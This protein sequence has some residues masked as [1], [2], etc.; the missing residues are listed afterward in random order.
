MLITELATLRF[1]SDRV[2]V[3]GILAQNPRV[4]A[5]AVAETERALPTF[6]PSTTN[7]PIPRLLLQHDPNARPAAMSMARTHTAWQK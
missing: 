5:A 3:G 7:F 2:G 1:I 4:L 6:A